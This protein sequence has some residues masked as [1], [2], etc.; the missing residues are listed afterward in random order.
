VWK[1]QA[2]LPQDLR[3]RLAL[4]HSVHGVGSEEMRQ[5]LTLKLATDVLGAGGTLRRSSDATR[6]YPSELIPPAV[7]ALWSLRCWSQI[8]EVYA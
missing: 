6:V 1:R 3:Q 8:E 2:A 5:P 7:S 4:P